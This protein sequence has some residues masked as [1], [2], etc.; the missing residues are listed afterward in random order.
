MRIYLILTVTLMMTQQ[1]LAATSLRFLPLNRNALAL[2]LPKDMYGNTDND[3]AKLYSL[4]N[5]PE[6]DS[7]L[8][9]IKGIKTEDKSFNLACNL[10]KQ[11]C[12]VVLNQSAHVTIDP[13]RKYMSYRIEGEVARQLSSAFFTNGDG[14]VFYFT[15]DQMFRI[16]GNAD[17]FVFE[18]ATD[19][20]HD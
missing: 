1:T 15:T 11:Q 12:Q 8:G 14:Q 4:L 17:L 20:L 18:A 2:V 13:Q 16:Y 19:G 7:P 5:V 10:N 9:K 3:F 6:Q